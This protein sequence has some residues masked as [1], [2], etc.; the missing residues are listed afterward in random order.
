MQQALHMGRGVVNYNPI[1]IDHNSIL[2]EVN[3]EGIRTSSM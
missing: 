1:Q 2:Q 3:D